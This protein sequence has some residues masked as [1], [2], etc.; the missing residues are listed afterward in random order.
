MQ[1]RRSLGSLTISSST[2]TRLKNKQSTHPKIMEIN[3]SAL[4]KLLETTQS[5]G[6]ENFLEAKI[7]LLEKGFINAA[8]DESIVAAMA[9]AYHC[10]SGQTDKSGRPY[11]EHCFSVAKHFIDERSPYGLIASAILHDVIEDTN[12]VSYD[13]DIIF[14]KKVG[15]TVSELSKFKGESYSDFID[16]IKT[17]WAL[18][19]KIQDLLQN[20]NL[21][22]L[23]RI[24]AKDL[25]RVQKYANALLVLSARLSGL[26]EGEAF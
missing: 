12:V 16:G 8:T 22:R 20:M 21:L 26:Q 13:L 7:A 11:F 1:S 2:S 5:S 23:P 3:Y 15:S 6:K 25:A 4:Y 10:H 14:G 19:I 24:T 17:E 18:K 9:I